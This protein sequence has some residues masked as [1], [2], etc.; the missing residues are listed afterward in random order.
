MIE[1][2]ARITPKGVLVCELMQAG[3]SYEKANEIADLEFAADGAPISE[4]AKRIQRIYDL[5]LQGKS[6]NEAVKIVDSQ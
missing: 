3:E 1:Y 2:R 6:Y 4:R 5:R